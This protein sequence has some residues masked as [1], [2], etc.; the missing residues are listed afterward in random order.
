MIYDIMTTLKKVRKYLERAVGNMQVEVGKFLLKLESSSLEKFKLTQF[1]SGFSNLKLS[2]IYLSNFAIFPT[3]L[4]N[5]SLYLSHSKY[6]RSI[7]TDLSLFF[8]LQ[9][10]LLDPRHQYE[11]ILSDLPLGIKSLKSEM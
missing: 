11:C 10:Y 7:N 5:N 8:I 1:S 3:S 6:P 4:S 9:S 2:N